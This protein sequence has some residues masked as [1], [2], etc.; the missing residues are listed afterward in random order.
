MAIATRSKVLADSR[1]DGMPAVRTKVDVVLIWV[2]PAIRWITD[3][4]LAVAA[5]SGAVLLG[6]L[7]I[8]GLAL[9]APQQWRLTGALS[10]VGGPSGPLDWSIISLVLALGL[11]CS[12]LLA[13]PAGRLLFLVGHVGL[14][15]ALSSAFAILY[16]PSLGAI[17][18]GLATLVAIAGV[19]RLA[20]EAHVPGGRD[21]GPRTRT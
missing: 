3:H 1:L 8:A 5:E 10:S 21:V 11:V 4:P 14:F 9:F 20:R 17:V 15:A 16:W 2:W 6:S 7:P 18:Y 13:S 19:A 12:R